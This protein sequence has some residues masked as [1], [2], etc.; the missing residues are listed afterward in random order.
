MFNFSCTQA[1]SRT[2]VKATTF[3]PVCIKSWSSTSTMEEA[4]L[5]STLS[6]KDFHKGDVLRSRS[7]NLCKYLHKRSLST[8]DHL[9]SFP[10]L[11]C[12]SN[13]TIQ[14]PSC[15]PIIDTV[16]GPILRYLLLILVDCYIPNSDNNTT[17]NTVIIT[18][19]KKE[20]W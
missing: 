11:R 1:G 9:W 12:C 5:I 3:A 8:Q 14:F 20:P 2:M 10:L 7:M 18:F 15:I 6:D 13:K 4:A 16:T 19:K 17:N